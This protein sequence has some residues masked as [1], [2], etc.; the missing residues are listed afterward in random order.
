MWAS[1]ECWWLVK[2]DVPLLRML[3]SCTG[4]GERC[5]RKEE[6]LVL[7]QSSIKRR[8]SGSSDREIGAGCVR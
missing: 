2:Q 4:Q 7:I 3:S 6:Q 8:V 5:G 1:V